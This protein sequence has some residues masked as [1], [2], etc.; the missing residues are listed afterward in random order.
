MGR[1]DPLLSRPAE[2][3][4]AGFRSD[5]FTLQQNGWSLAMEQNILNGVMR[6]MLH[7]RDAEL[8]MVAAD[9]RHDFLRPMFS[10]GERPLVF[11]IV[12]VARSLQSY[13]VAMDFSKFSAI[14]ATP[15]M[16]VEEPKRIEDFAIFAAPL[17]RTE[18][19]IVEPQ[20]VA[21]CLDLIKRLQAPNL[22][23]IRERNRQRERLEP[24]NQTRF[25][26]QILSLAA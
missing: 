10:Y 9:V 21:E 4:F 1:F 23:E 17:V 22:A 20:S 26:A 2:V 13:R 19:I 16:R 11:Q 5:T 12:T 7:H 15:T 6:L 14:D 25:H 3:H 24:S 8:Y 18:E